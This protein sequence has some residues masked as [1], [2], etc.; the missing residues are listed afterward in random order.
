M[1]TG[2]GSGLPDYT[3]GHDRA[4]DAYRVEGDP[5]EDPYA[6]DPL[7]ADGFAPAFGCAGGASWSQQTPPGPVFSGAYGAP[8]QPLGPPQYGAFPPPLPSSNS[9]LAGFVLGLAGLLMCGGLTSPFGIWFSALGMKE[10]GPEASMPKGGR[11]LAVAGL[12]TSLIGLIPL[13]FVL[14]Y[15]ALVLVGIISAA[16]S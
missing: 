2:N 9:A 11:G 7:A 12:V 3:G 14:L 6:A 5:Y 13:L 16:T 4:E 10:T 15:L 8:S 1:S